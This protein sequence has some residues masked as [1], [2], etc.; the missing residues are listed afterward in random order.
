MRP[1]T[2][3]LVAARAAVGTGFRLHGR[4]IESGLDCVGLVELA[5]R[6][7][8]FAG[9]APSGYALRS[10]DAGAAA[11]QLAQAGLAPAQPPFPGDVM[12]LRVGPAQLHLAIA[13]ETGI[14]H[15]DAMLRR[16]VERP[17]IDWPVLG[18]WRL[19]QGG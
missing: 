8:G 6:A 18:R 7:E 16:V 14:I 19:R 1:G 10:G 13:G 5:L 17:S 9:T 3:A 15:A 11:R 12:L 2:R 4:S